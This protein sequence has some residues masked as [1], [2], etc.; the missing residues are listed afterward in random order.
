MNNRLFPIANTNRDFSLPNWREF[1]N[2][3]S[4]FF[5]EDLNASRISTNPS[6]F[7][8]P[9]ANVTK[10]DSG[11]DVL[12]AAPG[13]SRGDF[14]INVENS[15]L[16]ISSEKKNSTENL[17]GKITSREF[18]YSSF[19]R[20]WSLPDNASIEQIGASYDAGILTISIPISENDRKKTSIKVD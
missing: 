15:V 18:S 5:D 7:S 13:F 16:T 11:F 4:S 9:R 8:V 6:A 3:F 2:L 12:L 10:T 1:D 19:S 14:D 20:S 17:S